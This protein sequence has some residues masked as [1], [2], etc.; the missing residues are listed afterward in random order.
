MMCPVYCWALKLRAS[1]WDQH[2]PLSDLCPQP[3]GQRT[4]KLAAPTPNLGAAVTKGY[5][6]LRKPSPKSRRI[7]KGSLEEV[8][9]MNA[10]G[11]N[12]ILPGEMS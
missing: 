12:R 11:I 4:Q 2:H 3:A 5:G 7:K 10:K 6:P 8:A 9:G 1:W